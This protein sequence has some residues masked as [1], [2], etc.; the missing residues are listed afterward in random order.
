[1]ENQVVM[2][3]NSLLLT[4]EVVLTTLRMNMDFTQ[5]MRECCGHLLL[6]SLKDFIEDKDESQSTNLNN[7]FN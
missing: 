1:M 4:D 6:K 5:V 3:G 2:K 7:V